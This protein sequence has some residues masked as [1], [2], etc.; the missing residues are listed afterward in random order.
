MQSQQFVD[1]PQIFGMDEAYFSGWSSDPYTYSYVEKQEVHGF[2][3]V[4]DNVYADGLD[5]GMTSMQPMQRFMFD[6][7]PQSIGLLHANIPLPSQYQMQHVSPWYPSESYRNA[8]P[9]RTSVSGNSSYTSRNDAPSPHAYNTVPYGTP[10]ESCQSLLPYHP[11]GH[12]NDTFCATGT[13]GASISLKEIEYAEQEPEPTIEDSDIID[14]KQEPAAEYTQPHNKPDTEDS[15]YRDYTDSEMGISV[16]DAESVQPL[17]CK[18]EMDADSDYKPTSR[19]SGKR[20]KSATNTTRAS[21]RRSGA[22]KDSVVSSS[23][24]NKSSRRP[25]GT[26][27]SNGDSQDQDD[28]RSFPCP[29]AG[30]NCTSTFASKNEWKRHVSTQHIK[31]GYWRCDLCQPTTDPNDASVLYHNDF[32]RKDLFTQHLRRM[33]AAQGSGA[34]HSKEHP[35]TEENIGEHQARCYLQLRRAPQHSIC[36][37]NGCDLDFI[38]HR[39][40]EERMEH[41]GRHLEKDRNVS[42]LLNIPSWKHDSALEKYLVDED[43]ITWEHG[44]WRISDGRGRRGNNGCSDED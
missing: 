10:I 15:V 19:S 17:D 30:Y 24:S 21:R 16:R 37:F 18:D 28:R 2:S 12:I 7:S 43:L 13:H 41:V 36:P 44:G 5:Q 14:V 9:D 1:L 33:H 6:Q 22:R 39:S 32:N 8:S 20:R 26:K 27:K 23:S 40:W 35:V 42:E 34:R 4:D 31:L 29:L 25:R 3:V 38:G 11:P